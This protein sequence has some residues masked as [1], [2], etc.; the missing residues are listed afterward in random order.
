MKRRG[1]PAGAPGRR[2]ALVTG[3]T[4]GIGF[5]IARRLAREGHAVVLNHRRDAPSAVRAL[6]AV[7]RLSR[8]SIAVRAD[9][10][11]AGQCERL[12]REALGRFGRLDVLVNNVGP[13]RTHDFA[14]LSEEEWREA[15]DG[16][17]SGAAHCIRH[18]LRHMRRRRAGSIVNIGALHADASPGAVLEAPAY[19]AAKAALMTLTRTLARTEGKHGIRVNAVSP[20]FIETE[21][22]ASLPRRLR[23]LWERSIPLERFGAPEDVAEAVAWLVSDRARYVS[24]AV[25]HVDGGLWI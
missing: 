1:R 8:R 13:F 21:N 9:V 19:Y 20:G 23:R 22:Y 15:L 10:S 7:R 25:L 3:S 5:A 4:R 18:A 17:L 11:D 16:N 24:G 6:R 14:A 2:V 12:V